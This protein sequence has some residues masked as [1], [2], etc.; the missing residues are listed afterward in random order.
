MLDKGNALGLRVESADVSSTRLYIKAVSEKIA[1]TVVGEAVQAGIV[2]SNSEVGLHSFRVEQFLYI[3]SC[4]NGAIRPDSAMRKYHVGKASQ[5][6][7]N[8]FEVFADE[9]RKADD[10]ALML[11]MRDVVTAS[12]DGDRFNDYLKG[13]ALTANRKIVNSPREIVDKIIE[14]NGLSETFGDGILG[15]LLQHGDL[16]QWGLSNAITEFC[17]TVPS[18][19]DSTTMERIG[20]EILELGAEKWDELV[21]A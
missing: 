20:G 14:I 19:E 18:Y 17:Q 21:A 1:G 13:V 2:I 4:T 15:K 12:F 7:D 9:T 16:T 3:L 5:E 10:K 11:K 6:L 8:A